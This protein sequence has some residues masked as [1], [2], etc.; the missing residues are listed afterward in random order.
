MTDSIG[1]T[2]FQNTKHNREDITSLRTSDISSRP[3]LYKEYPDKPRILLP[4]PQANTLSLD[5]CLHQRKSI[6]RYAARP[7]TTAQL[8]YLLWAVAGIQRS[9]GDFHFRPA[10]SAGA[11]Y[12]IE[13]YLIVN[14]VDGISQGIYHYAIRPHALEELKLGD[15]RNDIVLAT[16][17][18]RMH[19]FAGVVIIWTAIFQRSKFR[20]HDR[21]YR[22]IYLDAGHIAQNLALTAV[23]LGLASCQ[24][25]AYFDDEVNRLIGVNGTEESV[26][27]MSVVGWTGETVNP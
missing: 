26:I 25:G 13:T 24:V 5:Q 27:Y 6:R 12:P 1:D 16:Q 2:F 17:G 4:P 19:A 7:L 11:L 20:Y 23:G 14:N 3:P 21:A 22:L 18:Q 9:M 10:P 15:F 8:S